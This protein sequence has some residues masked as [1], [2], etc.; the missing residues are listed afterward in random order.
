MALSVPRPP[1][2][3]L[4]MYSNWDWPAHANRQQDRKLTLNL[5]Y[6]AALVNDTGGATSSAHN[7]MKSRS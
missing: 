5:T 6:T 1:L 7:Q 2:W 4:L 3:E